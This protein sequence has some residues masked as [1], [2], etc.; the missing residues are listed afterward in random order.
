[1]LSKSR[2]KTRRCAFTWSYHPGIHSDSACCSDRDKY[3]R[4]R[5]TRDR[6]QRS[7]PSADYVDGLLWNQSVGPAERNGVGSSPPAVIDGEIMGGKHSRS[8]EGCRSRPLSMN[9]D[10]VSRTRCPHSRRSQIACL[11]LR[12]KL[13]PDAVDP[14]VRS[15]RRNMGASHAPEMRISWVTFGGPKHPPMKARVAGQSYRSRSS[16]VSIES[17]TN[18]VRGTV[19]RD[20]CRLLFHKQ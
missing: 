19:A 16:I 10:Y 1:M 13:A 6:N 11:I 12:W 20:A 5:R 3:T 14:P 17:I 7:H 15:Q 4:L 18:G 8:C 9:N 2:R